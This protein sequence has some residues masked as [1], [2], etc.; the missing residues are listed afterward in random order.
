MMVSFDSVASTDGWFHESGSDYDVVLASRIR[1]S[2]NLAGHAFPHI[3]K[4][5]EE[6]EVQSDILSAVASHGFTSALIGELPPLERRMLLERHF[7]SRDFSLQA[8]KACL[9]SSDQ[10]VSGMVNEIDHLRISSFKGGR[11]LS[12]CL[13]L[14]DSVDSELER[15]LDYAVSVEWGYLSAQVLNCGT[16]MRCSVML[17]LPALVETGLIDRALKAIVQ[18]GMTV[19]GFFSDDD[20]SLGHMYQVS[21]QSTFGF[22]ESDLI[23]KLDVIA[24]QLVH[25]ERKARSEMFENSRTEVEDRVLRALG[26]L[27][28]CRKISVREVIDHLSSIRLGVALGIVE[29][30]LTRITAL[31]FLTQKAH[32]QVMVRDREDSSDEDLVDEQ[33]ARIIRDALIREEVNWEDLHV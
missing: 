32:V 15:T 26:I 6:Q 20:S 5:E 16:G 9:L 29:A 28:F 7:I 3:L 27:R 24:H 14:A 8:H 23:E 11:E 1:L 19:K 33:R 18:V 13:E 4:T 30:P 25:Y 10:S 17:H 21:N 31:L 12:G 2:R 22:T